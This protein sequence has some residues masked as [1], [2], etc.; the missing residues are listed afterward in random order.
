[1]FCKYFALCLCIFCVSIFGKKNNNNLLCTLRLNV[2]CAFDRRLGHALELI[3]VCST[4][5]PHHT[6]T[7]LHALVRTHHISSNT[8]PTSRTYTKHECD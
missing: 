1:V 7:L 3:W 5:V 2:P 8:E 4:A 6:H